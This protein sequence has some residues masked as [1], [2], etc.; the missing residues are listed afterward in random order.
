MRSTNLLPLLG[1]ALLIGPIA[2]VP[3]QDAVPAPRTDPVLVPARIG[4]VEDILTALR[5]AE[6]RFERAVMRIR[7]E[8]WLPD[9][10][11]FRTE[12]TMRVLGKTH[13]HVRTH[14]AFGEDLEGETETVRTPEGVFM[15]E[16]DPVQ[17]EV[18]T[19]MSRELMERVD[20]ASRALG[21]GALAGPGAEQS[22]SPL[23]SRMI[24]DLGASFDLR[25]TGPQTV[26]D[27]EV[28][29]V[30]G[31]R[32]EGVEV[33]ELAPEADQVDLLV[34]VRDGA[35]VRMTQLKDGVPVT[36]VRVLELDQTT[37]LQ[38][39]SFVMQPPQDATFVDVMDHPPAR[40]QILRLL[41]DARSKGWIDPAEDKTKSETGETK[42]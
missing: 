31:P 29:V 25:V 34:R 17:G 15:R 8:G 40:E 9:G 12:G 4:G 35:V 24:A 7:T 39:E 30:S 27:A 28:M 21:G 38:P 37:E 32:R 23:G 41:E 33:D 13:F 5:A 1:L 20:G 36:E 10:S 11:K 3:G 2:P 19:R 26:D 22:E 18:F 42:R 16:D 14:W 6:G